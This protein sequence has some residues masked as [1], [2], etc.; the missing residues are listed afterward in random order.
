M[1]ANK[2]SQAPLGRF[3]DLKDLPTYVPECLEQVLL[4][5]SVGT[6]AIGRTIAL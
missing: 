4:K 1:T 2:V 5:Q 6:L 3:G